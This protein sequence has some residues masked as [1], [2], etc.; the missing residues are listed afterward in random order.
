MANLLAARTTAHRRG[1]LTSPRLGRKTRQ[2]LRQVV[3]IYPGARA[4]LRRIVQ[5][6]KRHKLDLSTRRTPLASGPLWRA[7][8]K[9][10]AKTRIALGAMA[11]PPLTVKRRAKRHSAPTLKM[12]QILTQRLWTLLRP[13]LLLNH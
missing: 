13:V 1:I 8:R 7:M 12:P 11:I 2:G 10:K 4:V 6:L 3:K 5:V 9:A